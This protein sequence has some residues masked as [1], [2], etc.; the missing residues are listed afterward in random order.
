MTIL[1]DRPSSSF[2]KTEK[3][4]VPSAAGAT[5]SP[6]MIADPPVHMVRLTETREIMPYVWGS[7]K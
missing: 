2:C 3:S 7:P 6:S 1:V 5:T 4:V